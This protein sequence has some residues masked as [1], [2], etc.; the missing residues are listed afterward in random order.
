MR[1][2]GEEVVSGEPGVEERPGRSSP[3]K[4]NQSGVTSRFSRGSKTFHS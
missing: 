3:A 4:Q 1:L 2:L